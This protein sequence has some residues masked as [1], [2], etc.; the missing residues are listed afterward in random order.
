MQRLVDR[1]KLKLLKQKVLNAIQSTCTILI[2]TPSSS[3]KRKPKT[4][5]IALPELSV[6]VYLHCAGKGDH[7]LAELADGVMHEYMEVT[8]GEYRSFQEEIEQRSWR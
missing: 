3:Q 6:K 8:V 1:G 4:E 5:G 7:P 2:A